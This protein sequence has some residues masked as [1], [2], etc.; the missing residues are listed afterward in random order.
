M[1]PTGTITEHIDVAL[2]VL[3]AFWIFFFGLVFYLQRESRREGFPM[4]PDNPLERR[5][6]QGDL[7]LSTPPKKRFV[8]LFD[9]LVFTPQERKDDR[10]ISQVTARPA[11]GMPLIPTGNPLVDGVGPASYA[12]RV[13]VTEKTSE[14]HN[15]IV[16]MRVS[17]EHFIAE[18]DPNPVGMPVFGADGRFAGTVTDIWVDRSEGLIRYLELE[19]SNRAAPEAEVAVAV[20]DREVAVAATTPQ[21]DTVVAAVA[22]ETIEPVII[23]PSAWAQRRLM[24]IGFSVVKGHRGRV[25]VGAIT[26]AQFADIPHP[27]DPSKVTL[28]EEERVVAYFAGGALYATPLRAE[29]LL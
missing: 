27:S 26:A 8:T 13:D 10:D 18:E 7:S 20:V 25:D 14:G 22:V 11:P 19:L 9:G 16:P 29:P 4:V 23:E 15:R 6:R 17:T 12:M 24:P 21:G 5:A 2:V 3:Y 1:E 28:A